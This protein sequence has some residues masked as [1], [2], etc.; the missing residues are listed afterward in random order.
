M[1]FSGSPQT[2]KVRHAKN[3]KYLFLGIYI[4]WYYS[5]GI[6]ESARRPTEVLH[7]KWKCVI[8][9]DRLCHT[10]VCFGC[11]QGSRGVKTVFITTLFYV[12]T[13]TMMSSYS[14]IY[15]SSLSHFSVWGFFMA[16]SYRFLGYPY[17]ETR[18]LCEHLHWVIIVWGHFIR[19]M[20]D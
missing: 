18:H 19:N 3:P 16:L 4:Y 8:T 13:R 15:A 1:D 17:N 12:L 20:S 7:S 9:K 14:S 10:T 6:S 11:T 2:H 5:M